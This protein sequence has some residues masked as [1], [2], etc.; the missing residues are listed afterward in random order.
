MPQRFARSATATPAWMQAQDRSTTA[1]ALSAPGTGR[2]GDAPGRRTT[3]SKRGSRRACK[4]SK[5]RVRAEKYP[6]IEVSKGKDKKEALAGL[7]KW[8]KQHRRVAKYL[9]PAVCW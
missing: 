7:A 5:S 8:K 9:E 2:A 3:A 4:P 1:R 6:L